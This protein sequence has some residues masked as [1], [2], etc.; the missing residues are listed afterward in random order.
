MPDLCLCISP[1][2]LSNRLLLGDFVSPRALCRPVE[3][4]AGPNQPGRQSTKDARTLFHYWM[5]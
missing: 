3:N 1:G 5:V 2:L 4:L